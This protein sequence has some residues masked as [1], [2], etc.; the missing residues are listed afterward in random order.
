MYLEMSIEGIIITIL[1]VVALCAILFAI[2]VV[3]D[4]IILNSYNKLNDKEDDTTVAEE[5]ISESEEKET[6][7]CASCGQ[8]INRENTVKVATTNLGG[9]IHTTYWCQECYEEFMS[10]LGYME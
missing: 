8:Y 9:Y 2:L 6:V 7:R 3:R 5:S 4:K 1:C 10:K